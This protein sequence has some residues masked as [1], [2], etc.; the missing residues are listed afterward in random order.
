MKISKMEST[1]LIQKI[2]LKWYATLR[3]CI[4]GYTRILSDEVVQN[5]INLRRFL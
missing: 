5:P 2:P 1:V 3:F 4:Y